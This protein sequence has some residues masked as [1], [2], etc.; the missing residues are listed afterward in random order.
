MVSLMQVVCFLL[1]V[2]VLLATMAN[3]G[4]IRC[5]D[6]FSYCN[7]IGCTDPDAYGYACSD[8]NSYCYCN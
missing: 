6:D 3:A 5:V 4:N 1:S 2:V 7:A 8:G